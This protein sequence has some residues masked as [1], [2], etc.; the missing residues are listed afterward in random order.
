MPPRTDPGRDRMS[1]H[2]KANREHV[3]AALGA[4]NG[5][6]AVTLFVV[7]LVVTQ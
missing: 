7:A 3:V 5:M 6:L 1:T 4:V 2:Q